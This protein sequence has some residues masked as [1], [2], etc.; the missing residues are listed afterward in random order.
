M[1]VLFCVFV[2]LQHFSSHFLF[3]TKY[4]CYS[5]LLQ[6]SKDYVKRI[7]DEDLDDDDDDPTPLKV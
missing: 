3:L 5:K 4:L 6:N 2:C 7:N 1:S